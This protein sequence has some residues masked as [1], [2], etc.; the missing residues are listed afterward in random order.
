MREAAP[1]SRRS[2]AALW[3]TP[4][5][6]LVFSKTIGSSIGYGPSDPRPR[7]GVAI[8]AGAG[9]LVGGPFNVQGSRGLRGVV[10]S[11]QIRLVWTSF[12]SAGAAP[13]LRT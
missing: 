11:H 7:L 2:C 13:I 5:V 8:G 9:P 4:G 12:R 6:V 1:R 10:T 3:S